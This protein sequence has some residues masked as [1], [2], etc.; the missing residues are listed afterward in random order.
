MKRMGNVCEEGSRDRIPV[1]WLEKG[2]F[3]G[4]EAKDERGKR[5]G[6]R[7]EK[8]ERPTDWTYYETARMEP[9]TCKINKEVIFSIYIM[10]NITE[11][12]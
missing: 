6:R 3:L 9:A 2:D 12:K 8:T 11:I 7:E 5:E 1:T 10:L 4:G